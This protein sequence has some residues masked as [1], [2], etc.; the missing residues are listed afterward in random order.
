[1][2]FQYF[3]KIRD[4]KNSPWL[5]RIDFL[6]QTVI[7]CF[8]PILLI[9]IKKSDWIIV[10]LASQYAMGVWQMVSSFLSIVF[11]GPAFNSKIKHFL[12]SICYL[13]LFALCLTLGKGWGYSY[14][15]H[16]FLVILAAI[17]FFAPPWILAIYYYIV[18]WRLAVPRQKK[19]SSFLPHINF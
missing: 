6:G 12:V 11:R 19:H 13:L 3:L 5:K 16:G 14:A 15:N 4:I 8:I 18:T 2:N 9:L 7:F 1:M 10:I 17:G